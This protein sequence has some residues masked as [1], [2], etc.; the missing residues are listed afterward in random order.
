[1]LQPAQPLARPRTR[2]RRVSLSLRHSL[3]G[4]GFVLPALLFFALFNFY[5]IGY[6]LYLSFTKWDMLS[7]PQWVGLANFN[8]IFT[9]PDFQSSL[10]ITLIYTV[11]STVPLILLSLGLALLLNQRLP[12][13]TFFRVI[14]FIPTVMPAVVTAIVWGLLYEP[15]GAV[16][17]LIGLTGANPIPWISSAQYAIPA[18][19]IVTVWSAFGYDTIILLAGLQSISPEYNEAASIDGASSWAILRLIT[20]P[21]LA[22]RFLFVTSTTVAAVLTT[23]VLPFVMTNGGPGAA[24]RVLPLL[25]YQ[26]AFQ[27]LNAGQAS[28]MA[29]V[30]LVITLIFTALQ[31][32]LFGAEVQ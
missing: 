9:N 14:Y 15:T 28:A 32:R 11:E 30:L 24:T 4:F 12:G 3:V 13:D 8:T 19:D 1:M 18:L 7:P 31:F 17:N 26:S 29:L 22:P 5:P 16:N 20:L 27:F 10:E 6:A 2:R 25:I 23:F 21:L